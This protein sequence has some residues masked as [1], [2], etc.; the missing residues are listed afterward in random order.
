[1]GPHD[2]RHQARGLC[3]RLCREVRAAVKAAGP[4]VVR[5]PGES[6]EATR[7]QNV[8]AGTLP[9]PAKIWA[10]IQETAKHGLP[11]SSL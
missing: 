7:A 8:A 9:V 5:L 3:R 4:D 11:S 10:V 1:M 2:H 6:S